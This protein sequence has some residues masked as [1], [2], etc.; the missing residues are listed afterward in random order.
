MSEII[1]KMMEPKEYLYVY[2]KTKKFRKKFLKKFKKICNY[3]IVEN[4]DLIN[5]LSN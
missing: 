1:M 5:L 4:L 2:V 3:K